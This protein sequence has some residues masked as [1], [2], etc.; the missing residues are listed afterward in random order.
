M[1]NTHKHYIGLTTTAPFAAV[2][3]RRH[4]AGKIVCGFAAQDERSI[5]AVLAALTKWIK[6]EFGPGWRS[7]GITALIEDSEAGLAMAD[8][9]QDSLPLGWQT[10]YVPVEV[11]RQALEAMLR[12]Q[13]QATAKLQIDENAPNARL[14]AQA[15]DA[16]IIEGLCDA[17][18]LCVY[19]AE[20][21]GDFRTDDI[22]VIS[23]W[24]SDWQE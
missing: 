18:A 10:L 1:A 11:T 19:Q 2:L 15:L 5:A 13:G 20:A 3:A 24:P 9:A 23:N 7:A 17:M 6:A 12:V 4:F 16:R 8:I 22:T 21:D 14:L